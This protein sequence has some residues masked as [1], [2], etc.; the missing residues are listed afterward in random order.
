MTRAC[1]CKIH[2]SYIFGPGI[3]RDPVLRLD[4]G[5]RGKEYDLERYNRIVCEYCSRD[6]SH[7]SGA[8]NACNAVLNSLEGGEF[9]RGF[10]WG[11]PLDYPMP[12]VLWGCTNSPMH[13]I[14]EFPLWSWIG[15]K[16]GFQGVFASHT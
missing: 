7:L 15:W 8:L 1:G 12:G 9:L 6:L 14:E 4:Y 11:L 16:D 3:F 13:R 2:K 5:Y 10:L